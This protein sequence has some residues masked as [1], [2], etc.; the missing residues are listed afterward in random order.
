MRNAVVTPLDLRI[1]I[2]QFIES[3][4]ET[5]YPAVPFYRSSTKL[6]PLFY[7]CA[8]LHTHDAE[9][10]GSTMIRQQSFRAQDKTL[11]E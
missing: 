4:Q 3:M 1:S 8:A 10:R 9:R 7:Q 6:H 11:F 2:E 5:A